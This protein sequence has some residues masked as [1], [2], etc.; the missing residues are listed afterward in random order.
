MAV[1]PAAAGLADVAGH[2]LVHGLLDGLPVG[3]LRLA[4]VR[5]DAPLAGQSVDQDLEMQLAHPADQRLAGLVVEPDDER[6]VLVRELRQGVGQLVLVGLRLRLDGHAHHRDGERH[7]LQDDRVGR[8]AQRVARGGVLQ[9]DHRDDVAGERGLHVLPVIGVHLQHPAD[10][11][12]AVLR[13]VLDVGAGPEHARVHT[14][15][16]QPAHVRVGHDLE[17]Q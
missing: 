14:E 8:V 13:R 7:G 2:D 1:L 16:G 9:A 17:G 12:L 5:P 3:D 15:V 10:A 11:L 4:D 6:G